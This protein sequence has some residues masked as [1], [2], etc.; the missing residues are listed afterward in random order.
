M[1]PA[2]RQS[3]T[4]L[5]EKVEIKL[6]PRLIDDVTYITQLTPSATAT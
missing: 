1:Q 4:Q 6:L 5:S 3:G 2:V